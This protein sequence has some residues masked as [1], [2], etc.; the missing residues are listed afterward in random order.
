[1]DEYIVKLNDICDKYNICKS[2]GI[3]HAI[4]VMN[5][6]QKALD[7][8]I[9]NLNEN[10][11]KSVLLAGLLHDIDDRKFFPMN[12]NFENVNIILENEDLDIKNLVIQMVDLVSVSKNKDNIPNYV[13]GKE[14]MLYPR[15]ADR[16][17][18]MGLI[19]IERCFTYSLT[20]NNPLY[21]DKT[22]RITD[23]TELYK[24]ATKERYES[25]YGNSDSMI[26]HYYDKLIYFSK[27][28]IYNTFF[29][30][31]SKKRIKPLIDFVLYFGK[32]GILSNDDVY[33]FINQY[34]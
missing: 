34:K 18:A 12:K 8:S 7:V 23:E 1:M 15:Y 24:I 27:F 5:N 11:K 29:E 21:I 6:V 22:I 30:D 9:F 10:E 14:W 4:A 3:D 28:P 16:L 32:R 20:S 26:D 19:G 13:I 2:H 31:E 17:E 33:N 25:Y